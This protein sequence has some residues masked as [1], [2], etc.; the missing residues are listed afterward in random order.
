ML[1]FSIR[2]TMYSVNAHI[3]GL[4]NLQVQEEIFETLEKGYFLL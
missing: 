2:S 1:K 3:F 4:V